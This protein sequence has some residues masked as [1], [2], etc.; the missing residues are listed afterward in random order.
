MSKLEP[1]LKEIVYVHKIIDIEKLII[2][3]NRIT[4][5]EYIKIKER[6]RKLLDK[7]KLYLFQDE[8]VALQ[9]FG[10]ILEDEICYRLSKSIYRE[11]IFKKPLL[12][13][14]KE[15]CDVLVYFDNILI[16]IQAKT[17]KFNGD[18]ERFIKKTISAS[19]VQLK[20]SINRC[21]NPNF[22]IILKNIKGKEIKLQKE[23]IKR[24]IGIIVNYEIEPIVCFDKSQLTLQESLENMREIPHIFSVEEL[25]KIINY[26]DTPQDL[27]DYLEKREIIVSNKT[28]HF[29]SEEDIIGLYYSSNKTML[30]PKLSQEEV[31]KINLLIYDGFAEDLE[32]GELSQ[33]LNKKKKADEPS[34]LIDYFINGIS[35]SDESG[36]IEIIEK[37]HRLNRFQRRVLGIAAKEK[38][39]EMIKTKKRC[40]LR[41]T[42]NPNNEE[43]GFV[44]CFSNRNV[45]ETKTLLQN[46]C[47]TIKYKQKIK[48]VIGIAQIPYDQEVS[49]HIF[50]LEKNEYKD[51]EPELEKVFPLIWGEYSKRDFKEFPD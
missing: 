4:G 10:Y 25:I 42:L 36:Y 45:E 47:A 50:L 19:M 34:L 20:S 31:K 17:A 43:M 39:E 49:Q 2:E 15:L 9:D 27:L 18:Y 35:L 23:K 14:G 1:L 13:N 44:F 46:A 32:N 22:E 33:L 51:Y 40:G 48:E 16:L 38:Y 8:G 6:V 5:V 37:L 12:R 41:F 24:I 29:I 3:A 21:K 30:P 28:I 11:Y 7:K 26:F